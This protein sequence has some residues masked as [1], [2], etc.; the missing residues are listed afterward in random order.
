ML[1]IITLFLF[2][3]N[4]FQKQHSKHPKEGFEVLTFEEPSGNYID[5]NFLNV[6]KIPSTSFKV[7]STGSKSGYG[8]ENAFD[9]KA[10]NYWVSDIE[11]NDTY[12]PSIFVN[13]TETLLF[14]G[15]IYYPGYGTDYSVTPPTRRFDGFPARLKVYTALGDEPFQLNSIFS[16]TLLSHWDKIQ[17]VLS[18]PVKCS[19]LQFEFY[20]VSPT[21]SFSKRFTIGTFAAVGDLVLIKNLGYDPLTFQAPTGN[22]AKSNYVNFHK[23][24]PITS[25]TYSSTGDSQ[26]WPIKN[27]F[28]DKDTYW[29]SDRPETDDFKPSIFINFTKPTFF[30]AFLYDTAYHTDRSVTP[31]VRTFDGFP[32]TLKVYTAVDEEPFELNSVFTGTLQSSWDR[33]SFVLLKPVNCTG[34]LHE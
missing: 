7:S 21:I 5:R 30:E 15:F 8:V 26:N 2:F 9:N 6:H 14:E 25:F 28:D 32:H 1:L 22:Y 34:T 16:G 3:N 4:I 10:N 13:F 29:V 11:E 20:D 33:I 24:A 27:A 19:R 31:N 17:Y 23:L 18:K 12:H